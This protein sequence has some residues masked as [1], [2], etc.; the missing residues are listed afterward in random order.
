MNS[1]NT[2]EPE[3]LLQNR[4]RFRVKTLE[5]LHNSN[6]HIEQVPFSPIEY[7]SSSGLVTSCGF[8][9]AANKSL[10]QTLQV[11]RRVTKKRERSE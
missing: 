8:N 1:S 11:S 9:G 4:V 7:S 10:T 3:L 5:N 2:L 6:I